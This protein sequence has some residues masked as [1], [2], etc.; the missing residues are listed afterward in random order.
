MRKKMLLVLV[1]VLLTGTAPVKAEMFG[2]DSEVDRLVRS[3]QRMVNRF[4]YSGGHG[5]YYDHHGHYGH[6]RRR[7]GSNDAWIGL[8]LGALTGALVYGALNNN[9]DNQTPPP[10]SYDNSVRP[11]D[12]SNS[13]RREDRRQENGWNSRLREQEQSGDNPYWS[14]RKC[15]GFR[16]KNETGETIRVYKDGEP[17]V[18]VRPGRAGCGDPFARY[19]AEAI[20]AVS[21]GYTARAQVVRAKP[22]GRQGGVWVWR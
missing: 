16:L 7:G 14:R 21:D 2:H 10:P 11:Y 1:L 13:V 8:G 3:N 15:D 19:E 17:Y 5:H 6:G 9:R 18:V 22:E 20:A 4:S 12:N